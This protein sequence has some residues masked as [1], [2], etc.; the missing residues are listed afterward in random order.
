MAADRDGDSDTDRNRNRHT[1]RHRLRQMDRPTDR[2]P[3]SHST[4]TD[5]DTDTD[6]Q[7]Q[8]RRE[9]KIQGQ[10]QGEEQRQRH[11]DTETQTLRHRETETRTHRL[12]ET[13][14]HI[15]T[16]PLH[17]LSSCSEFLHAAGTFAPGAETRQRK[18]NPSNEYRRRQGLTYYPTQAST[19]QTGNRLTFQVPLLSC[20]IFV[21]SRNVVIG[22]CIVPWFSLQDF[23]AGGA[24]LV[25]SPPPEKPTKDRWQ[26]DLIHVCVIEGFCFF[27]VKAISIFGLREVDGWR[28]L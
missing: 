24:H 22:L 16:Q 12:G 27:S 7:R 6:S 19:L 1:D 18:S 23:C 14:T 9:R 15:H 8:S 17:M 11:G 3:A 13:H 20:Y 5:S 26:L 4:D 21:I 28:S 2:S 25:S 10:E